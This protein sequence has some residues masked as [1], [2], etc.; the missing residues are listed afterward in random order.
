MEDATEFK[1]FHNVKNS[2]QLVSVYYLT[3]GR[4]EEAGHAA[5]NIHGC[6]VDF[7]CH[8]TAHSVVLLCT[9]NRSF[10]FLLLVNF[11]FLILR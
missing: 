2:L 10:L 11:K 7:L 9:Q 1:V 4:E 8:I 5:F 3:V 6:A